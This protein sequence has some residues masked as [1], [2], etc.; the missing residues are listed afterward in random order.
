MSDA[1]SKKALNPQDCGA[2]C[3]S[4]PAR[5]PS[6]CSNASGRVRRSATIG[7]HERHR[8]QAAFHIP[9]NEMTT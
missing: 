7:P 1:L 5:G 3:A 2:N 4:A 6:T 9:I 8:L